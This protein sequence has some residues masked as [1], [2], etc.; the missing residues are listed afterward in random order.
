MTRLTRATLAR[1]CLLAWICGLA[2]SPA[3]ADP[4][5]QLLNGFRLGQASVAVEEILRGGPARDGIPALSNP[6]TLEAPAAPW[7][8][9][10]RVIG[11]VVN[12]EARAYPIAVLNWHELVNDSLGG[13]PLL[14]TYCPLCGTG[15]VFRREV[16]GNEKHFGVSGL[17]Y[18]SDLLLYDRETESLW[19]QI[20]ATAIAGP[21]VGSRLALMRSEHRSWAAWKRAHPKTTV[22]SPQTGHLRDYSR[23]PYGTY[24][25]SDRLLFPVAVDRRY[26]AKEPTLGLRTRGGKA[27]AYPAREVLRAGGQMRERFEGFEVS[28]SYDAEAEEFSVQAPDSVEVIEGYWFAWQAFHPDSSVFAADAP[29]TDASQQRR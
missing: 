27:R 15:M 10:E 26:H 9:E 4:E 3:A 12:G 5:P 25:R 14:V 18:R 22:L 17:L 6:A 21:A 19:S 7:A 23:S 16:A 29:H 8:D 1:P 24:S 13:A 28:V 11:L 20:L 2:V